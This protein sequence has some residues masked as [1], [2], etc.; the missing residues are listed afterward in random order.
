LQ[1]VLFVKD[2][3]SIMHDELLDFE[4]IER[5][6]YENMSFAKRAVLC[7]FTEIMFQRKL[8]PDSAFKAVRL[9]G[10]RLFVFDADHDDAYENLVKL[11]QICEEIENEA[12]KTLRFLINVSDDGE[13]RVGE[14]FEIN[15]TYGKSICISLKFCDSTENLRY[16]VKT[17]KKDFQVFIMRLRQF[18]G[19]LQDLPTGSYGRYHVVY[20]NGKRMR[21]GACEYFTKVVRAPLVW[22]GPKQEICGIV[23]V[24]NSKEIGLKMSVGTLFG[25]GATAPVVLAERLKEENWTKGRWEEQR[26]NTHR[27]F[28]KENEGKNIHVSYK[29]D[30][31][32]ERREE[33]DDGGRRRSEYN[34]V[35]IE[36]K[37]KTL[38]KKNRD[39][40]STKGGLKRIN[41]TSTVPESEGKKA[42]EIKYADKEK[43]KF[44]KP[45]KKSIQANDR[46]GD[47][48]VSSNDTAQRGSDIDTSTVVAVNEEAIEKEGRMEIRRKRRRRMVEKQEESNVTLPEAEDQAGISLGE[49][50]KKVDR[51]PGDS[52]SATPSSENEIRT[53]GECVKRSVQSK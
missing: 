12:V 48:D 24:F 33:E 14:L 5:N 45:E 27:R 10:V 13:D 25:T 32:K 40:P 22:N 3:A 23:G 49:I 50:Q 7:S 16:D 51:S 18:C 39:G 31:V 43:T 2:C 9:N 53:P 46:L 36:T 41:D 35:T 6:R 52:T 47:V 4:A 17:H 34:F 42:K 1:P 20:N 44:H 26:E 37:R 30:I 21:E 38:S 28:E 19:T 29:R 8:L 11:S 15:F